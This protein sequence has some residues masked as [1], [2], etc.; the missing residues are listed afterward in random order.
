LYTCS[1]SQISYSFLSTE[2]FL[3]L[4]EDLVQGKKSLEAH[5]F[6]F[7][8]DFRSEHISKELMQGFVKIMSSTNDQWLL[9]LVCQFISMTLEDNPEQTSQLFSISLNRAFLRLFQCNITIVTDIILNAYSAIVC[10]LS[11][12]QKRIIANSGVWPALMA[13]LNHLDSKIV[14]LA[15]LAMTELVKDRAGED[16][17]SFIEGNYFEELVRKYP[18]PPVRVTLEI[19]FVTHSEYKSEDFEGLGCTWCDIAARC[20]SWILFSII[21]LI[22]ECDHTTR[23]WQSPFPTCLSISEGLHPIRSCASSLSPF[24]RVSL[25]PQTFQTESREI[26]CSLTLIN[27]YPSMDLTTS[28]PFALL[29][30][31]LLISIRFAS[32]ETK[33]PI[34]TSSLT[35]RS[36]VFVMHRFL[37]NEI[38]G[39]VKGGTLRVAVALRA[40][41][42]EVEELMAQ[43]VSHVIVTAAGPF[44]L[45]EC[46]LPFITQ[47]NEQVK[48][49]EPALAKDALEQLTKLAC[50]RG[51]LLLASH[52]THSR[53]FPSQPRDAALRR[54]P[55]LR[56]SSQG[57]YTH[58]GLRRSSALSRHTS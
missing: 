24:L 9:P 7:T 13:Y 27:K 5:Y 38:G 28:L 6:D 50:C 16:Y 40:E 49:A 4:Q 2:Q 8:C 56:Y 54:V 46:C 32:L 41:A 14:L 36:L 30:F 43:S 35:V 57:R 11:V 21:V 31:S 19:P 51:L 37:L 12:G 18:P 20:S 42:G 22:Q 52:S 55:S 3:S 58:V 44:P 26:Y 17:A 48:T 47:R 29:S 15:E 39:F 34:S 1:L 45:P 33:L 23:C 25:P 10:G 53:S